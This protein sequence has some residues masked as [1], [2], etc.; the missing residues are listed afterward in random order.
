MF[1]ILFGNGVGQEGSL[2][3]DEEQ[4]QCSSA[5]TLYLQKCLEILE[6]LCAAL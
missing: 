1:F 6:N 4:N 5:S 3:S 2:F